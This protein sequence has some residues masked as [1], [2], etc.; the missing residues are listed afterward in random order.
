MIM[1]MMWNSNVADDFNESETERRRD[2]VVKRMLNTPPA[3]RKKPK[4][5]DASADCEGGNP[6]P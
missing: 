4:T 1:M 5:S 3:P 2:E 6:K